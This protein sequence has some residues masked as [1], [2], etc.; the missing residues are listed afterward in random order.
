MEFLD[1]AAQLVTHSQ[2]LGEGEFEGLASVFGSPVQSY[3]PT[4][5]ESGSFAK[6]LREN[7]NRV[8]ILL[9]HRVETPIGRPL[10]LEETPEGLYVRGKISDTKD[11]RDA[12]VLMR[13]GVLDAMSIGFDPIRWE[14][15]RHEDDGQDWRHLSEI[16]LWEI[17][18][19]TFPADPRAVITNVHSVQPRTYVESRHESPRPRYVPECSEVY[20]EGFRCR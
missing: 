3:V 7:A 2:K 1:L 13:D 12:L 20:G 14:M 18:V 9:Q 11:G 10:K 5:I 16:K 15:R 17:S 8:K 19:V 6:T 4:V